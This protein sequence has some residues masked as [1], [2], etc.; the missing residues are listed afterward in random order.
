M[1]PIRLT[2]KSFSQ[3]LIA[4][5]AVIILFTF[6]VS[7]YISYKIH[8]NLFTDEISEQFSKTNEQAAARLDLQ[9]RDIYRISNFIVFHPYVQQ[10][11][12]RS[13][14]TEQRERTPSFRT[15]MS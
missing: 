9:I 10:V 14:Q 2:R 15:R 3:K 13:A 4:S 6:A 5:L 8:L 11:L 1:S 7:G 12:E